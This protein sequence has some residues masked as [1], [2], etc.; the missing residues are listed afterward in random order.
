MEQKDK[1]SSL[2]LAPNLEPCPSSTYFVFHPSFFW[3]RENIRW[4]KK[5]KAELGLGSKFGIEP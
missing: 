3:C 4:S 1:M 5:Q 2:G